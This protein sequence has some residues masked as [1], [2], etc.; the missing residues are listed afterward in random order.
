MCKW[1][2]LAYAEL[3]LRKNAVMGSNR[4]SSC[5]QPPRQN[6]SGSPC[7]APN[8]MASVV[9]P[10]KAP[11]LVFLAFLLSFFMLSKCDSPMPQCDGKPNKRDC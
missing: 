7:S 3:A 4:P 10:R 11:Q 1:Q 8:A 9:E 6:H 5:T 2:V